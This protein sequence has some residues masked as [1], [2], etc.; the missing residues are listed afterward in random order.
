MER[1]MSNSGRNWV[2]KIDT[3]NGLQKRLFLKH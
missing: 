2:I 1:L 3:K